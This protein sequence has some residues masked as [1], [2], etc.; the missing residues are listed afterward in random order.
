MATDSPNEPDPRTAA[1]DNE[2]ATNKGVSAEAP[3][4]GKDDSA[5]PRDGSPQG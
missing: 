5:A 4:E 2:D 3:A 1:D